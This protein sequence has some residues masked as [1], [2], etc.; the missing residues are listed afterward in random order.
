L[1]RATV[2]TSAYTAYHLP[3]FAP[4]RLHVSFTVHTRL[5][6]PYVPVYVGLV[7]L[8][9]VV[10]LLRLCSGYMRSRTQLRIYVGYVCYTPTVVRFVRLPHVL[11][12]FG[13]WFAVTVYVY[14]Y[15]YVGL[16][17]TVG[18]VR[19]RLVTAHTF[20]VGCY[21]FVT[22]FARLRTFAFY[23]H[24]YRTRLRLVDFTR[25][26]HV[27]PVAT[28]VWLRCT[29]TILRL[30]R[31]THSVTLG[32]HTHVTLRWCRY[33]VPR[34]GYAVTFTALVCVVTLPHTTTAVTVTTGSVTFVVHARY[35][36]F[37]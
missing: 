37:C 34:L 9:C 10:R 20:T 19:L 16:R 11:R 24:L 12:T 2:V 6:L 1:P 14:G 22:H 35:H 30:L 7:T 33:A 8:P 5:R 36:T 3:A 32:L 29:V 15:G 27:L 18:Y 21:T 4:H 23:A 31:F 26:T 17:Y 28:R 25:C 13:Y